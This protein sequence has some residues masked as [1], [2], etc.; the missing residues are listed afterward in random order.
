MM[1]GLIA[2]VVE[3]SDQIIRDQGQIKCYALQKDFEMLVGKDFEKVQVNESE[4]PFT[5]DLEVYGAK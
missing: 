5:S 4:I 2:K 1:D 3:K